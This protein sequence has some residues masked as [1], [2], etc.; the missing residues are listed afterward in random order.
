MRFVRK[1][2][3]HKYEDKVAERN[4]RQLLEDEWSRGKFV[5][6][7]L[8]IEYGKIAESGHYGVF[9][10]APSKCD[11][12]IEFNRTIV[13]ATHDLACAYNI[14][15]AFF[16]AH[17]SGGMVALHSTIAHIH[18]VAPQVLVILDAKFGDTECAN[19]CYAE[20]AF[21]YLQADAVTVLPYL[22]YEALEP[23]FDR[24]D[25]GVFVVCHSSNPGA[26][27]LQHLPLQQPAIK[28]QSSHLPYNEKRLYLEVISLV[29]SYWCTQRCCALAMG[30]TFPNELRK[31][32]QMVQNLPILMTGVVSA[33][34]G[35]LEKT[36]VAIK[37]E[38]NQG[39]LLDYPCSA[40]KLAQGEN[41]AEAVH[42]EAK[43][44]H[45]LVNRYREQK[46]ADKR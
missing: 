44:L 28:D 45:D 41:F 37:D 22:G 32:R 7:G 26:D 46:S 9:G 13:D 38:R 43:T 11:A 3:F 18:H 20:K 21:D 24:E 30:V 17:G 12:I 10:I 6:V 2:I 15:P 35:I 29:A 33:Q 25:K 19:A 4:F 14:N 36:I 1:G 27:E 5:S 40:T 39:M 23:F 16:E 8:D 31:V 42:G 34:N